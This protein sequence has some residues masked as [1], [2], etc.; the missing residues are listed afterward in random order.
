LRPRKPANL[1]RYQAPCI[2]LSGFFNSATQTSLTSNFPNHHNEVKWRQ[3]PLTH[4]F[5]LTPT[6]PPPSTP[7]I[8]MPAP[9]ALKNKKPMSIRK[10]LLSYGKP[11]RPLPKITRY[12]VQLPTYDLFESWGH[13][14][15]VIDPS[16][17]FKVFLQNPNG[18]SIYNNNQFL[19]QDLQTCYNYGAGMLCLPETN[20]NWNQGGQVTT[21]HQLFRRIWRNSSLQMSQTPDPFLSTYQPGGTLTAVCE[22]WVSRVISKGGD[23]FGL[24]RWS[25]ITLR[26]K[27]NTKVTVVT[28]Y[29]ATPSPG[30][31][32]YYHQ[33]MRVLSRLHREQNNLVPPE[34]RQ[35]FI[36]DLQS[37][38][39][40]LVQEGHQLVVAMDANTVYDPDQEGNRHHLEYQPDK[41]TVDAT[42]DGKLAT[43]VATCNLCFPL[44]CQH[45]TR[46]FPASHIMGR[47]QIDYI[48]VSHTLLP[49]V[50][51]SGVLSHQSLLRGDH[52]P[53]Y[54][55]LDP[56][57]LFSDPAYMIEPASVR[58]LCLQDPRIV[59]RYQQTLHELLDSHNV[60]HRLEK[61]QQQ[62][63][64][65]QWSSD[66]QA[67]YEVLNKTITESMLT[68]KNKLSKRIT[69]TYQWSPTLKK[70]VQQLRFWNMPLRQV[71]NQPVSESQLRHLQQE[72]DLPNEALENMSEVDIKRAQNTAYSQ[73][74]ELQAKHTELREHFLEDL[75]EAIVL[76][77]CPKLAKEGMESVKRDK[78]EKQLKQLIS[79][80]KLRKMYRKLSKVLNKHRGKGL[81][82]IDIPDAAASTEMTGDPNCPKTWKGPWKSVT[83]P[84]EIAKARSISENSLLTIT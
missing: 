28:A 4:Y 73:L 54:I 29:N 17:T 56:A 45:T 8:P 60:F 81:S 25:Y 2:N 37:W 42:H 36:L 49:A 78:A 22:N 35:Q 12:T 26:G 66:C 59:K 19:V 46:P 5:R 83:N 3:L 7:S 27:E 43:L 31:C 52:R 84:T 63:V 72:G 65:Q 44:A 13:S 6:I 32:T 57:I 24:G 47:N 51:R 1:P 48:F 55:D 68:A 62:I 21:I 11:R 33:Q 82:Q 69:T 14:L 41:L 23:P 16:T 20:A 9:E 70:A 71:K 15:D 74:K 40:S 67:E 75:A 10:A 30:E 77:R 80:E 34:P 58:Q 79:R 53:Y 39:E 50:Q 38:L 61:L 64:N 76:H 18:L